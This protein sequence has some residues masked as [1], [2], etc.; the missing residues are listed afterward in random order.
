MP[1]LDHLKQFIKSLS[2]RPTPGLVPVG[3]A[4]A[5][6]Y[7]LPTQHAAYHHGQTPAGFTPYVDYERM[8]CAAPVG[9]PFGTRLLLE[10][11]DTGQRATCVVVD[12]TGNGRGYDMWPATSKALG[13]GPT[14]GR[15][16]AGVVTVDVWMIGEAQ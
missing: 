14:F 2:A 10:R 15:K 1:D 11:K 5:T 13:F 8:G 3:T 9:I 12:R 16:D 4:R 7:W 6:W